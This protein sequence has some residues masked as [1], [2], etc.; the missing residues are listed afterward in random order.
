MRKLIVGMLVTALA[1]ASAVLAGDVTRTRYEST[2]G[3]VLVVKGIG[4]FEQEDV[5]TLK[6]VEYDGPDRVVYR[7]VTP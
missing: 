1:P 7:C 6:L 4:C 2:D 3:R 5:T